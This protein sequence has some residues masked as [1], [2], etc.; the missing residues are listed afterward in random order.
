MNVRKN[1]QRRREIQ[2]RVR[3]AQGQLLWSPYI[4]HRA[5]HLKVGTI[6]ETCGLDVARIVVCDPDEDNIE[7]ESLMFYKGQG[8]G[9]CS[10]YNC[11]PMLLTKY[12]IEKRLKLFEQGGRDAVHKRYYIE[13]CKMSEEQALATMREWGT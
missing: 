12:G 2:K 8:H 4:R 5:K 10:I 6:I 13:D 3:A 9:S 11:A 1:N 7:Y